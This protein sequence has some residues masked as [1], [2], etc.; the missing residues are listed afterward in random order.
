MR[1]LCLQFG[2]LILTILAIASSCA[3]ASGHKREQGILLD[4][5]EYDWCHY[6]CQPFDSPTLYFCVQIDNRVLVGSGG[7]GLR[8]AYDNTKMLAFRG[9]PISIRYNDH[10]I[11]IVRTDGKEMHLKQNY[12]RDVFR[13]AACTAEVH[14]HWLN[15][16]KN[17]TRPNAVPS[18][19]VLIP[20]GKHSYFWANCVF[21]SRSKW[22]GCS[23]WDSKGI[24]Y[25]D[26]ECVDR[27]NHRAVLQSDL[28]I[29]P[30]TTTSDYEFHLKNGVVLADWAKGR[31]NNKPISGSIPPL[32]P[33]PQ[34]L[35]NN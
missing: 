20:K 22:D 3:H 8:W 16:F 21:D 9:K 26:R 1:T 25:A 23:V 27:Q 35:P 17:I 29:D 7:T 4:T 24:K 31:I 6:D 33:L 12:S 30:L 32:P 19:A 13:N 15:H 14:V 10:S 5:S 28:L 11:W 2:A 34:K 18:Q